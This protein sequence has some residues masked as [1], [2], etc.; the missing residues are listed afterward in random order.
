M[1]VYV[2]ELQTYPDSMIKPAARRYGFTW[3]HMTADSL[4]ELLAMARKLKLSPAHIQRGGSLK[5]IHFDLV[6]SK[7]VL[8]IRYGA[9]EQT[10]QEMI[11]REYAKAEREFSG[12]AA[13]DGTD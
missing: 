4:P 8:A 1:P 11:Q 3:C 5:L 9:I 6:P 12:K 13:E 7:R 2:D 10:A